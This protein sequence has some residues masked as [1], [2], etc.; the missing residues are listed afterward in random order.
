MISELSQ[1]SRP[2]G[3][4]R[5]VLSPVVTCDDFTLSN[6]VRRV[7]CEKV[8]HKENNNI[9]CNFVSNIIDLIPNARINAW[10][11]LQ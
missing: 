2:H 6:L 4:L 3:A 9:G 7:D 1:F 8:Y 5:Y 10:F 11:A